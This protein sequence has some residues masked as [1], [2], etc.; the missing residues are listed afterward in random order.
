MGW[1]FQHMASNL[2]CKKLLGKIIKFNAIT[3]RGT[4]GADIPA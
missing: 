3:Q 4:A 1:H 2:P